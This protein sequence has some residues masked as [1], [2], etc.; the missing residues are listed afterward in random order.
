MAD[1]TYCNPR[2][3]LNTNLITPTYEE[4]RPVQ[5][6]AAP[7]K[8]NPEGLQVVVVRAKETKTLPSTELL[9]TLTD[10]NESGV[11][12]VLDSKWPVSWKL[13][14]LTNTEKYQVVMS[15][16]STLVDSKAEI[17][18]YK[19]LSP[20]MT[21]EKFGTL[22]KQNYGAL[23]L[24]A[25]VENANRIS[26][27]LSPAKSSQVPSDECNFTSLVSIPAHAVAFRVEKQDMFGCFHAER[28]GTMATDLIVIDLK[29]EVQ[30]EQTA[31][32]HPVVILSMTP[33][34]AKDGSIRDPS[35]RNLT[36][37]LNSNQQVR[38]YLES[39]KMQGSLKVFSSNG[40][41]ENHALSPEQTLQIVRKRLPED[42]SQLWRSV[43][44]ET[45][46]APISYVKVT[47]ANVISLLIPPRA[48]KVVPA[49]EMTSNYAPDR[50]SFHDAPIT[51]GTDD[52]T[53]NMQ[54]PKK[55]TS[56]HAKQTTHKTR[57]LENDLQ[58]LIV[59]SCKQTETVI[60][61]PREALA[62]FNASAATLNE[63]SCQA[64]LNAT[65]W[66]FTTLSTSC[67]SI[68]SIKG[69]NPIMM[70]EIYL[71]FTPGSEFYNQ[72]IR[73][74]FTCKYPP[75]LLGFNVPEEDLDGDYDGTVDNAESSEMYTLQILRKKTDQRIPQILA[76]NPGDHAIVAVGD[77][78]KV[79]TDFETRAF[80]SLAIEQ[81]WIA[82]H[83]DAD[84]RTVSEDKWL[85]Y[86]GCPATPNVTMFPLPLGT[87]PAFA[88]S[89]TDEHRK[90]GQFYLFCIMGL[91]S[92]VQELTGGNLGSCE[93]PSSKC[94]KNDWHIGSAAQQMSRR[95][96]IVVKGRRLPVEYERGHEAMT[97][98]KVAEADNNESQASLH[99]AHVVMVG[100]PA[101]IAVAISVA[102]FLIGAALTGMLCCI[103]HRKAMPKS[104][105]NQADEGREGSELQSMLAS[106]KIQNT[107][108]VASQQ[109][110]SKLNVN[111]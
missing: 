85:I 7:S 106:P 14:F 103:H 34:Q 61:L 19:N 94:Q 28:A 16:G 86:E 17:L 33:L 87:N 23:S 35:P 9:L 108:L 59:K 58:G 56:D 66:V 29:L 52:L 65:H 46:V 95:G 3:I 62:K 38:W 84:Q 71:K 42:Y 63:E 6:C 60:T 21:D 49:Q 88:F 68:N 2:K 104:A 80:L 24:L 32:L 98:P 50:V 47:E 110:S 82:D 83:P 8:L 78:L 20:D 1:K 26:L 90:M 15:P 30:P 73:I 102:S 99:S 105:R 48:S 101:E 97:Q 41:V 44:A 12:L 67:G 22:V 13:S 81:C 5:G 40:P 109:P 10:P 55:V 89:V 91:C 57:Q 54:V 64:V 100:V 75:G 77:Q 93:D 107:T 27:S 111:A 25:I 96:P 11:L 74:P 36:L 69:N 4:T 92:P 72:L 76:T 39:W 53:V 37:V 51:D 31:N 18:K 45:G 43:I 70:N 79:E